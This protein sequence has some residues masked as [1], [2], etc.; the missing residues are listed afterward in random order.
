M[1]Q[2][3]IKWHSFPPEP[4]MGLP[5]SHNSPA[6]K[7]G[8]GA[9]GSNTAQGL[10]MGAPALHMAALVGLG[11]MCLEGSLSTKVLF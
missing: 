8:G 1:S 11:L 9:K 2:R 6:G 5:H 4:E 10:L 7:L 3:D